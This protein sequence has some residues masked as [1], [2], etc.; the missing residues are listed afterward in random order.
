MKNEKPKPYTVINGI[1]AECEKPF[2]RIRE[3]E[4][5]SCY[6]LGLLQEIGMLK[7]KIEEL[8]K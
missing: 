2:A 4:Q 5:C 3:Y 7:K 6:E 8:E 1:C